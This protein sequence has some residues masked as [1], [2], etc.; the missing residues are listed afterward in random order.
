MVHETK[1][2]RRS[3]VGLRFD[4]GGNGFVKM[5]GKAM[6][7]YRIF[8]ARGRGRVSLVLPHE[9]VRKVRDI[10]KSPGVIHHPWMIA[11]CRE[12]YSFQCVH[13]WPWLKDPAIFPRLLS[14]SDTSLP[15]L[16]LPIFSC[17]NVVIIYKIRSETTERNG[18][19]IC[20]CVFIA[21][22]REGSENGNF[23]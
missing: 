21:R 14:P 23:F 16:R 11:S 17:Y 19:D 18:M 7:K 1:K 9:R 3:N 20:D 4:R 2:K 15:P 5:V 8:S 22:I 12:S 13:S 10:Q 6:E